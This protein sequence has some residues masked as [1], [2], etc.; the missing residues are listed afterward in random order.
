MKC[1]L[2]INNLYWCTIEMREIKS[3]IYMHIVLPLCLTNR[4]TENYKLPDK[5]KDKKMIFK[6]YGRKRDNIV[7][8]VLVDIEK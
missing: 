8:Y 1:K 5:I 7:M 4:V 6:C 2:F 3:E